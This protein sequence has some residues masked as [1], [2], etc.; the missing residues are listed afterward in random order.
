MICGHLPS[1]SFYQFTYFQG[2]VVIR[3]IAFRPS[4]GRPGSSS[5]PAT[6]STQSSSRPGSS[7]FTSPGRGST[8]PSPGLSSGRLYKKEKHS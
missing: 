7:T 1:S 4:P 3:P 6:G 5:G 2:K 8:A